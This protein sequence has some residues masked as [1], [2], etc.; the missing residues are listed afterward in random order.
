MLRWDGAALPPKLPPR[1]VLA[2]SSASKYRWTQLLSP[3]KSRWF[4][5]KYE[6]KR[7]RSPQRQFPVWRRAAA[8]VA[9]TRRL[10]REF[11]QID[12]EENTMQSVP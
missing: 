1:G 12:A 11:L 10:Y 7:H 2:P 6:E 8:A 4:T 5:S 3:D 9:K